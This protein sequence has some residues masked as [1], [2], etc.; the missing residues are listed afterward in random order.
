MI[1]RPTPTKVIVIVALITAL[2][3]LLLHPYYPFIV[4]SFNLLLFSIGAVS[5]GFLSLQCHV[6][7]FDLAF[8]L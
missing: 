1:C 2:K 5:I 6:E 4:Y 7:Y 3:H 8:F